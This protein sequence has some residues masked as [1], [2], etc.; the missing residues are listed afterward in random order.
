MTKIRL[1]TG[2]KTQFEQARI[3]PG[4]SI[5]IYAM[6]LEALAEKAYPDIPVEQNKD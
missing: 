1:D 4:E 6:R 3:K 2:V 5:G